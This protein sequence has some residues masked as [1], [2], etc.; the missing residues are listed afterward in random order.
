MENLYSSTPVTVDR[1]WRHN[2]TF[3]DVYRRTTLQS[4]ATSRAYNMCM[5]ACRLL[6]VKR[7]I[8]EKDGYINT[9][10]VVDDRELL[11]CRVIAYICNFR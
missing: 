7:D 4:F 8:M 10:L 5:F 9:H 2:Y 11:Q 1:Y 6:G 3:V